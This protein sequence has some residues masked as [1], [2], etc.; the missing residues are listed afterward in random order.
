MF[1]TLRAP[2][3]AFPVSRAI[4]GARDARGRLEALQERCRSALQR[5]GA[6][7]G[8]LQGQD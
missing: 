6:L 2:E 3:T 8:A 7:P 5:P 1:G 4:T